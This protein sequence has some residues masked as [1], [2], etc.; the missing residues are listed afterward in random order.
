MTAKTY[1]VSA[2]LFGICTRYDGGHNRNE[3]V[4]QFCAGHSCIPVCP[5]QLGGLS[6]PRLAAE[7]VN[8]DGCDVLDQ[9]C[10]VVDRSGADVTYAFRFGAEQVLQLARLFHAYGAVLKSRSPSCGLGIIHDGTFYGS[11]RAGDGVAAALLK[12]HGY[13]VFSELDLPG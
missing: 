1:L 3:G 11:Y 4:L 7:I 9:K 2:C 8:G 6:T 5:E 12:R 10:L 13:R